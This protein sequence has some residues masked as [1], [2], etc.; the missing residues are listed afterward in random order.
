VY[1]NIIIQFGDHF[2]FLVT[3]FFFF[4][5]NFKIKNQQE[6]KIEMKNL[7]LTDAKIPLQRP[8]PLYPRVKSLLENVILI[9]MLCAHRPQYVWVDGFTFPTFFMGQDVCIDYRHS[10]EIDVQFIMEKYGWIQKEGRTKMKQRK[11]ILVF[12]LKLT[13]FFYCVFYCSYYVFF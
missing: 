11:N 1:K 13:G 10:V 5:I 12:D 8:H 7:Q 2:F 9:H 6:W 4:F 3:S